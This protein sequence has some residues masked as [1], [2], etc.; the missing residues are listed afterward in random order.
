MPILLYDYNIN[1]EGG[2]GKHTLL[3]SMHLTGHIYLPIVY[4]YY[5]TYVAT[6]VYAVYY[7]CIT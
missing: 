5:T 1:F 2:G 3:S 6:Q 4:A 7:V